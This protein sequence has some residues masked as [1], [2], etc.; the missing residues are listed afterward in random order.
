MSLIGLRSMTGSARVETRGGTLVSWGRGGFGGIVM[1][2]RDWD[3][4]A[5]P[6]AGLGL[7][8]KGR[9]DVV[10]MGSRGTGNGLSCPVR[11]MPLSSPW[12]MMR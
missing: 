1:V 6:S 3:V 5:F 10:S 9:R 12:M 4:A 8:G 2:R 7:F 11:M